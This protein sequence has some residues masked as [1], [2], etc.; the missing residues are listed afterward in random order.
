MSSLTVGKFD[1]NGK[2]DQVTVDLPA[3]EL[4]KCL[5]PARFMGGGCDLFYVCTRRHGAHECRAVASK[6]ARQK[7]ERKVTKDI[8]GEPPDTEGGED[9]EKVQPEHKC[10]VC[11]EL[12]GEYSYTGDEGTSCAGKTIC[13]TCYD[14]D[15]AEPEAKIYRGTDPD[16]DAE[17]QM[18]G[19]CR[20]ETGGDFEVVWHSTDAWRGYYEMTS[21]KYVRVFSD[22]ILSGDSSE[23]ELKKLYDEILRQLGEA[24]IDTARCFPR[25]SNVFACGLEIWVEKKRAK[26]AQ[27]IVDRVR[28]AVAA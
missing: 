24:K 8:A 5:S 3:D 7:A 25:T 9:G 17:V 20:N 11:G 2:I 19:S 28:K 14:E 12:V 6:D 16:G 4:A 10:A 13:E 21:K 22:T 27:T 15:L 23:K 26:R 1:E 18:I